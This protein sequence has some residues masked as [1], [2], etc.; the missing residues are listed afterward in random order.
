MNISP[1]ESAINRS[2][3]KTEE[4]TSEEYIYIRIRV[5]RSKKKK[6]EQSRKAR[7]EQSRERKLSIYRARIVEMQIHIRAPHGLKISPSLSTSCAR[8]RAQRRSAL[9]TF[10]ALARAH[11][12]APMCIVAARRDLS[13]RGR[14]VHCRALTFAPRSKIDA[15]AFPNELRDVRPASRGFS[16]HSHVFGACIYTFFPLSLSL[17]LSLFVSSFFLVSTYY[18]IFLHHYFFLYSSLLYQSGI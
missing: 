1:H 9:S 8:E 17:S 6:R 12:R 15:P 16:S 14:L 10:I 5:Q 4:R 11:T 18:F 3:K 2:L 13:A 7:H